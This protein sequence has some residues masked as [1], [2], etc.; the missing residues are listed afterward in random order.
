M[1]ERRGLGQRSKCPFDLERRGSPEI[2]C[3][4]K[5]GGIH[6]SKYAPKKSFHSRPI[7][8]RLFCSG[9]K[10]DVLFKNGERESQKIWLHLKENAPVQMCYNKRFL[11]IIRISSEVPSL[12]KFLDGWNMWI[13]LLQRSSSFGEYFVLMWYKWCH[14]IVL[15]F[16]PGFFRYNFNTKGLSSEEDVWSA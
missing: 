3:Y 13:S 9:S 16:S 11:H 1:L 14:C 7:N 6:Q 4:L 12:E 15:M 2:G 8:I 5:K 10:K